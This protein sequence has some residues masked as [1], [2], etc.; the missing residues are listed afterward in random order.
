[1]VESCL[2]AASYVLRGRPQTG[3]RELLWLAPFPVSSIHHT[4]PLLPERQLL[5]TQ[6]TYLARVPIFLKR[7]R[8]ALAHTN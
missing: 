3:L 5:L 4:C 7:N 6:L 2:A 1:M 8:P